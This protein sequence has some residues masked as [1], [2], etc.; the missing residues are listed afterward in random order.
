[1]QDS[2]ATLKL[3]LC[4]SELSSFI[5]CCPNKLPA[6]VLRLKLLVININGFIAPGLRVRFLPSAHCFF[7]FFLPERFLDI[8]LTVT[9]NLVSKLPHIVEI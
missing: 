4:F 2:N 8:S 1:M 9:P 7:F 3:I 6:L 5:F